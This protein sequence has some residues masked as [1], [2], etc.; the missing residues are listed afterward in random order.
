MNITED[1][2]NLIITFYYYS[3]CEYLVTRRDLVLDNLPMI[4][5]V[6]K[7]LPNILEVLAA[8]LEGNLQFSCV[9]R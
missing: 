3:Q 8:K 1:K 5:P 9:Q 6:K 7:Q 4:T 2:F